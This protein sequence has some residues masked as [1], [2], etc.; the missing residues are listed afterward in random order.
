MKGL[1]RGGPVVSRPETRVDGNS[2]PQARRLVLQESKHGVAGI[3]GRVGRAFMMCK[4]CNIQS[5]NDEIPV[6]RLKI[7]HV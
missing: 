2:S 6:F 1:A 5:V 4:Y 7:N 3:K